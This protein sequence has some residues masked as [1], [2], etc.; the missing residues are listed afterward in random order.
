MEF[1]LIAREQIAYLKLVH[2]IFNFTVMCLFAFH[3]R[4][5]LQIRKARKLNA[6][7][8][9]LAIKRHRRLGPLL[10][11][12]GAGGFCAGLALVFLDTGNILKYPLHLALGGAILLLGWT[13]L[14]SKRIRGGNN[15]MR[16]LHFRLGIAILSLYLIN[17]ILGAGLLL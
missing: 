3:G 5:G 1:P 17:V 6:V 12:L 11:L 4:Y 7:L 2:G 8:P 15:T 10:A 13:W 16:D 9:L 14:V